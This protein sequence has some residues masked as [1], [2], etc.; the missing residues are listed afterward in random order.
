MVTLE[1][2]MLSETRRVLVG[3]TRGSE[4][5]ESV[6]ARLIEAF[7]L[8]QDFPYQSGNA[9]LYI[10]A[11][12]ISV[13]DYDEALTKISGKRLLRQNKSYWRYELLLR[14]TEKA[15]SQV[16]Y[17]LRIEAE[18]AD[19]KVIGNVTLHCSG[20]D[21]VPEDVLTEV[22]EA[23]GGAIRLTASSHDGLTISYAYPSQNGISILR[24][25]TENL[26][27]DSIEKN[28]TAS[29]RP[30]IRDLIPILK[31]ADRGLVTLYGPP[32][33]GKT[34][35]LKSLLTEVGVD[36]DS[37]IC[38]P[39]TEFIRNGHLLIQAVNQVHNPIVI[40][41]DLGHM[42]ERSFR[43]QSSDEFSTFLN[44][45]DGLL[46]LLTKAVFILTFNEQIDKMDEA[47]IRPGRCIGNLEIPFLTH[48]EALEL[49]PEDKKELLTENDTSLAKIY[50]LL[51][52]T[53][54]ITERQQEETG[55]LGLHNRQR[56]PRKSSD[57][58]SRG[59][60]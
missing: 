20:I 1:E 7:Y 29:V 16:P 59:R 44:M 10:T 51:G 28:Y 52:Q 34:Y 36:R 8:T 45:S 9:D 39:P 31:D 38:M 21:T 23:F 55:F 40:L 14:H 35:L 54:I 15:F 24:K 5:L 60:W 49:L 26:S 4:P 33:T 30:A 13:E 32:G 22:I 56:P 42:F 25:D 17:I 2:Q 57:V 37:L 3:S 41:E 11:E 48:E 53:Q 46:S 19:N 47:M 43:T 50:S 18:L 58:S 12:D 27:F 6:Q